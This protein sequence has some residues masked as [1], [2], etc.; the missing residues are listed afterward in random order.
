MKV[1]ELVFNH[2][3][4]YTTLLITQNEQGVQGLIEEVREA[5]IKFDK[6]HALCYD[7]D[8]MM[9]DT[10]DKSHPLAPYAKDVLDS[11]FEDSFSEWQINYCGETLADCLDIIAHDLVVFD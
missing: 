5:S 3:Y 6:Y 4:G 1:Y 9:R 2:E 8:E 11:M 10:Y 7:A